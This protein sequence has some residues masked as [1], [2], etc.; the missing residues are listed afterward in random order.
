[1]SVAELQELEE[2]RLLLAKGKQTGVS[3]YAEVATALA[4]VDIDEGDIEELHGYLEKSEIDLV[5]EASHRRPA[6]GRGAVDRRESPRKPATP[7][8]PDMTT[9]S[10]Q[11][12]L[13]ASSAVACSPLK[14]VELAERV[15]SATSTPSKKCVEASACA[16]WSTSPRTTATRGCPSST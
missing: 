6:A 9:D 11:L 3:T 4:E 5:E 7:V 8:R 14:E 13:K 16:W 12:F 10:L 2:V 15:G 1:M